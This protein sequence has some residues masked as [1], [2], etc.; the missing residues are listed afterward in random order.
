M[1]YLFLW[2]W[3]RS[4]KHS[5]LISHQYQNLDLQDR[6]DL[7]RVSQGAQMKVL[8]LCLK[9]S[10]AFIIGWSGT[11]FNRGLCVKD[12]GSSF[13][14]T[15]VCIHTGVWLLSRPRNRVLTVCTRPTHLDYCVLLWATHGAKQRIPK[16]GSKK[17]KLVG[18][19]CRKD[20][21]YLHILL[22]PHTPMGHSFI[23]S[24][25]STINSLIPFP[26]AVPTIQNPTPSK[27]NHLHFLPL[28]PGCQAFPWKKNST[29]LFVWGHLQ[30]NGLQTHQP[31]RLEHMTFSVP[32]SWGP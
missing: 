21:S 20:S 29:H 12:V 10:T 9:K 11:C 27:F 3:P 30:V 18:E 32:P 2:S 14:S 24:F 6:P 23:C 1:T 15:T 8:Y 13:D 17:E 19:S 31:R 22:P 16:Q 5:D 26:F 28:S 4:G 7:G 25:A